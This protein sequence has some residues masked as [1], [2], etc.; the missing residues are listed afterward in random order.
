VQISFATQ[1]DRVKSG[2][3]VTAAIITDMAQDVVV[4]PNG[5]IKTANNGSSYV[6]AFDAAVTG[7]VSGNQT[8]TTALVPNQIQI[9]TGLSDDTSTEIISG[10]KE[11][12]IIITKSVAGTTA[13]TS[14]PSILNAVAGGAGGA[15]RP[16]GL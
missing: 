4:V 13:K 14:T 6:Q 11:G 8:F 10:L 15:R 9:Q 16:G 3:S 12:D 7:P 5:A 1:D 2:M